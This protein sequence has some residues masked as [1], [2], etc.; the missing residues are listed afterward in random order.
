VS[1]STFSEIT[2]V[3]KE[4]P[5]ASLALLALCSL[6]TGAPAQEAV[7]VDSDT[8]AGLEAR[9][10]GPATMSGRVSAV[11]AAMSDRLTIYVGAA[12]GGLWKSDDGG[13]KFKSIFDKHNPSIGA[14]R[15]DP[16]NAKTVWVGTGEP[17]M[18]NSVSVGDGVYKSTDGGDNWT[19]LGLEG[20]EHIVRIVID[21]KAPDTVFVC[22]T[23]TPYRDSAERGVFRT[24]D[25]GRT[26]ER[27]LFVAP[28][29]GCSDL[30]MDPANSQILV[31]G[32]WQFRRQPDFFTSGG[33][34]SGIFKS[35]DGGSTWRKI[36]TG[37]PEGDLGRIALSHSPANPK[38]IFAT[39]EA[40]KTG[41]YRSDDG[42]ESWT[43][44]SNSSAVSGRPFYFS[45]LMADPKNA[46]RVYKAT[47]QFHVSDDAGKTFSSLIG[48]YH[49]DIHGF[50]INPNNTDEILMG[51]DGGLYH[52]WNR[53]ASWDFKD[54]L[55]LSQYYHVATDM[56][57]PYNVYGGLQDN[58]TWV[59]PSS[60][61]GD[62]G[63]KHW[64]AVTGGDGF[65]A[66]PDANDDDIVYSES[67]GGNVFRTRKSNGETKDIKP[68]PKSGEPKYRYNWNTPIHLSPTR[69][70]TIYIGA[71]FLFRSRD[72]GDS[73]E[74]LSPD[75]TT[76][77]PKKQRQNESGGLTRDNS[78]AENHTTIFT[79]AESPKNESV[80]WVG[81]DDGNL[82]VTRDGGKTWT[83]TSAN[84][85]KAGVPAGTWV[86]RI[87]ASPF[88]E[89]TAFATFDGHMTGDNKT[90]VLKTT[91][92]GA[93]WSSIATAELRGYAHVI[94]QD[95]VNPDLL[96]LG[97]ETGLFVTIDGGKQWA[98]FNGGL[99]NVPVRDIVIHPR[100]H[101]VVLATHGRGVYVIDDISPLRALDA[102]TLAK[103]AAI[104]PSRDKLLGVPSAA[105]I[106][107]G[108]DWFGDEAF[109][110][111]STPDAVQIAYYL[112]RRHLVGDLKVE[113]Y[114][115]QGQLVTS[116]PGGK[117]R[118][119]NRV[120]WTPRAKAPRFAEGA[121]IIPSAGGFFGPAYSD[122][123]YT[124]KLIKNRDTFSG[125]VK[126]V[127]DP[128]LPYSA[129]D[130]R[131]QRETTKQLFG[132]VERLTFLVESIVHVK[133]QVRDRESKLP[134][135][136]AVRRRVEGLAQS[137][138]DQHVALVAQQEGEG[139][140]GEEKLR[141][142]LGALYGNVNFHGGRP[143]VSQIDRMGALTKDL[144]AAWARF[145]QSLKEIGALNPQFARKK[146]DPVKAWTEAEWRAK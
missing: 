143:T 26:W 73:W 37:L 91:D 114:D 144:D 133:G 90:Y 122:G 66:F 124:V 72:R 56:Q 3:T 85:A 92:G 53:G 38:R 128:A 20:T 146:L 107:G 79:I 59:G 125:S 42:G 80:I 61:R 57:R 106:F 109:S 101:D 10:I 104:L 127:N 145:D 126:L 35:T 16:T 117:R 31:A 82:Q 8:F 58:S 139:I 29:T 110:G 34:G 75:L 45:N 4:L 86:S 83:N 135:K 30:S 69:K 89:K 129:E 25:G 14:V 96:F 49:G 33:P 70:G 120:S 18:R 137:L 138:D 9:S 115:A 60:V 12:S 93:T 84:A 112:K 68:S 46:D 24:K 11:D 99:P 23:G 2:A 15:I 118:G 1:H 102:S 116:M 21:P 142:E 47:Y 44:T 74:R 28:N 62:V 77:D 141:E 98:Q 113:I 111:R 71:Q 40:R 100:D 32:L 27:T 43:L 39:V 136:D 22:A 140:S 7:K 88:D 134:E 52:S 5:F 108:N 50:W 51:T 123:A 41:M 63:N 17:W 105:A 121:G 130:R 64:S 65:W 36:S 94:E 76:N 13:V 103:D 48:A 6:A 132:L 67:Q 95:T 54:N 19:K 78:T 87:A 81:T 97:T 119:L 131:I 55:P